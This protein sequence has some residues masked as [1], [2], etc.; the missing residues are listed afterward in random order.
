M[1][2]IC[3]GF[4]SLPLA[5]ICYKQGREYI[6]QFRRLQFFCKPSVIIFIHSIDIQLGLYLQIRLI[7]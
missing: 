3:N 6:A 5:K 1:H 2:R 7:Y 4:Q